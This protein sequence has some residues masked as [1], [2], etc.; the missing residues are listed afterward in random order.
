MKIVDLTQ[1]SDEWLQW[2]NQGIG[3]TDIAVILEMSPYKTPYQLYTEKIYNH[4]TPINAAM[5]HGKNL[6]PTCLKIISEDFQREVFPV[7]VEHEKHSWMHA[8]LDGYNP[9]YQMFFEIKCPVS[10][11]TLDAYRKQENPNLLWDMQVQWQMLVTGLDACF[12][13]VYDYRYEK[14]YYT[15]ISPDKELHEKMF[16]EASVFFN[17]LRQQIAPALK[18]KEYLHIGKIFSALFSFR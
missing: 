18:E 16:L 3:S 6:E 7:C 15:P 9:S 13:S 8:S 2:R 17:L 5:I 4:Q 1:G 12:L 11:K 14:V 10:E